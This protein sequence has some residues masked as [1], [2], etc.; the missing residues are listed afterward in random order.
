VLSLSRL[1]LEAEQIVPD[2]IAAVAVVR[3]VV[4][5]I[6]PLAFAKQLHLEVGTS[7]KDLTLCTDGKRL[8]QILLNLLGNS[9]K[10]TPAG[11]VRLDVDGRSDSVAFIVRDTGI[12]IA[13]ENQAHV[14]E[15]FWQ[16]Q[17]SRTRTVQGTGLGLALC[18]RLTHLL[19]GTLTLESELG[20]GTTVTLVLPREALSS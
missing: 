17:Q 6:E 9:V 11:S 19:G 5:I 7:G 20:E 2:D 10:F 3:D 8:R 4:A 1:E 15:A 12:G 14:F 18:Q 16:V 13:P